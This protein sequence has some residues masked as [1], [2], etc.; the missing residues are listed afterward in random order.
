MDLLRIGE[1]LVG[2]QSPLS[3]PS[4][5][6]CNNRWYYRFLDETWR[7]IAT[8]ANCSTRKYGDGHVTSIDCPLVKLFLALFSLFL[9][10]VCVW[11]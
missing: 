9:R 10:Q 4:S 2:S 6:T 8:S 1:D 11:P 3:I 5:S 7:S